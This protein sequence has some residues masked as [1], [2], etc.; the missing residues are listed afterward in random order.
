MRD[1]LDP[2]HAALDDVWF[3]LA[4]LCRLAGVTEPWVRQRLADGL[5][6]PADSPAREVSHFDVHDLRRARRMASLE[7]DFDAVPELASLVIDL[8]QE[9]ARVRARLRRLGG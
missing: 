4:E 2:L 5:L 7:R 3:D 1:P 6:K 9:L 8:E